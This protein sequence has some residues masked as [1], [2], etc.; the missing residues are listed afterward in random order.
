MTLREKAKREGKTRYF[1]GEPCPRGHVSERMVSTRACK[2]CLREKF[3]A[4]SKANPAKVVLQSQRYFERNKEKVKA[5]R[6]AHQKANREDA[7]VRNRR[8]AATH[9][10]ELRAAGLARRLANPEKEKARVT[11][12]RLAHPERMAAATARRRAATLQQTP[13]WA[14]HESIGMIYRAAE[15]IRVT[16]FDVHVDHV[17]PLQGKKVSG[18]HVHNNLKIIHS[19]ANRSKSNHFSI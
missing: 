5:W 4:W 16:G 9:R 14:D 13:A 15:V 10:E 18:L 12:W 2:E 11:A 3:R 19:R 1:T 8:Y 17:V 6:S 7:N